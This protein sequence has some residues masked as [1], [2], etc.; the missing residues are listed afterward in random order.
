MRP[1]ILLGS[2]VL[3]A[4]CQSAGNYVGNPFDGFGGFVGDTVTTN[5]N[6]N[7][8]MGD[9]ENLRL[10]MGQDVQAPPL[11]PESG[12][13]WPGPPPPEPTLED[14]VRE[15]NMTPQ[16]PSE[17]PAPSQPVVPHPQPRGSSTPPG[18]VEPSV[19]P[20]LPSPVPE[21]RVPLPPSASPPMGVVQTPRG[22]AVITNDANGV[23]QFTLPDG[24]TGRAIENGNGTMTL[25]HPDGSVYSVPGMRR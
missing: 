10:A 14:I 21:S 20:R 9:S 13:V 15:Q 12:N 18:S 24:A 25:I 22:Q 1:I 19:P 2:V 11:L 8:P 17:Q 6:P 16:P 7:R 23:R 3:L 5:L 4:G